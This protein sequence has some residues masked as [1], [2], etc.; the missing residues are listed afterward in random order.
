MAQALF[1]T[2]FWRQRQMRPG[3]HEGLAESGRVI[4]LST[5]VAAL[6]LGFRSQTLWLT[7]PPLMLV[8]LH[9]VGRGA[10]GTILGA[11]IMF[12]VG[13]TLWAV[14]L[15]IAS[16]GLRAYLTAL[17]VKPARTFPASRC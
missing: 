2:A 17:G 4:V 12:A 16:G 8:I 14:P 3:D 10:A 5:F 9:R 15:V 13:V 1:A 7:A 6:A 11:S